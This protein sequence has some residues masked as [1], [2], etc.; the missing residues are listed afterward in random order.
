MNNGITRRRMIAGASG[1]AAIG[2]TRA[3]AQGLQAPSAP[4]ALNIIDVAGNLQLTQAGID[5]FRQ[6][7]PNLISRIT[8]SRAPSPELPAKLKAQQD[9]GRVDIDLVLTGPGALSD[10]VQQGLWI[11]VWKD[12][13]DRLPKAE[14]T[15]HPQAL[16]MQRNFGIDQGVAVAYSPSGPVFEYAPSRVK[17][18]PKTASDLLAWVKQNPNRFCYA[19]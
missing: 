5:R 7:N 3:L 1:L 14:D 16:V 18:V 6:Q 19:R 15:Y 10:G 9:A 17:T 12:Y 4:V 13:A 11:P 8:Y 2:G